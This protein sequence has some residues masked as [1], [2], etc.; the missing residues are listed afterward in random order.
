MRQLLDTQSFI[1]FITGSSKITPSSRVQIEDNEN[2]LSIVSIWEIAIKSSIG[3]L[4]LGLSI[5]DLVEQQVINNSIEL[6]PIT[7]AHLGT[8][9]VLPLHHRD[10][11]DC[12]IISQAI[13]EQMPIVGADQMFDS[14]EVERLW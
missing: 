9:A 7:V 5:D 6:L 14:Y 4:N 13:V 11:F 8:V 1:W 3:K 10:P 12:L 2:F